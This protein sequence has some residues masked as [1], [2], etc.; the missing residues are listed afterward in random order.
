V[1]TTT[2][3]LAWRSALRTLGLALACWLAG[4]AHAAVYT[5]IWDPPF[6]NPFTADLGWRGS[7]T[8]SVPPGCV[9]G[10]SGDVDNFYDCDG[11]AV[12][13]QATV[14]LYDTDAPESPLATLIFD[15]QTLL[16]EALRFD[17]GELVGVSTGLSARVVPAAGLG[18]Y[19]I[20]D[21]MGFQLQ[22][23]LSGG[24]R[25]GVLD[26]ECGSRDCE[27]VFNDAQNFPPQ[28]RIFAVS[29]PGS[30]ALGGL[31]LALVAGLRRRRRG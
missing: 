16:I 3:T 22:F 17:D 28:F 25:L 9:L 26:T 18:L 21:T 19:A 30:A 12:V 14:E 29:E 8:F 13:T 20:P 6:G 24:P 4:P 10:G 1:T 15:V 31:A 23:T 2:R 7:A 11:Q 5:G 27:L